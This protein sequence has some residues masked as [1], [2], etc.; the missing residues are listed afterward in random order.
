MMD[1]LTLHCD[2]E[3]EREI[4]RETRLQE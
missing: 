4:E 1:I 3:R 2:L